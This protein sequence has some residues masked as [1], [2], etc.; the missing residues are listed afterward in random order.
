[1]KKIVIASDSFKGCLSSFEI[2]CAA[3]AGIRKVLPDCEVVCIPVADGGEGTTEA[4]VDAMNGHFVSCEVHD[5]LMNVIRA[6]Y[7]ILG[8]GI[9]AV[10]EM[11]SASGLTLVPPEKRNPMLTTTY[12]TGE[13]IKD[14]LRRGCSRFLIGIGGSATNDAGTGMLQALGYRFLDIN[15]NE[16]N[17][18]GQILEHIARIDSEKVIPDLQEA[19]FTIACD[20]NNPFAGENG[21]A[22]VYAR[23]KGADDAMIIRLDNGLKKFAAVI[24]ASTEKDIE[25]ISGAGAAGGLGGGFLAFLQATLKPGIQMVLE[26]LDFDKHIHHADLIITGEGKLDR[27]T[28]MGK[29][30]AGVLEAGKRRQIPVIAI[31]GAVED[32]DALLQQGFV[33]V[34]SIQP[35]PVSLE[36]AMDKAFASRQV[37]RIVE[38]II[39]LR[40]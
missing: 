40:I 36:Q 26:A 19:I 11:A 7:G 29:T 24:H 35:G 16:L 21:A 32:T 2:A 1:M 3:E 4:L 9:T 18:G 23:Q 5:P 20:V 22:F 39:R 37:E 31:G 38:Q 15:G 27:Q 12:G 13:M 30:P 10:I 34:L 33:A 17:K 8:D 14:A 28:G 6:E 25:H